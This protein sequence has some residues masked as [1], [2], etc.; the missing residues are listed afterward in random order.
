MKEFHKKATSDKTW[1]SFK[2]VFTEKYNDLAEKT[3][4]TNRDA[5]FHSADEIQEIR[6]L[7][8]H[9]AMAE[10]ANKNIVTKLTEAVNTLTRNNTS[11]TKK[12]SDTI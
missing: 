2:K 5:G 11:L 9:L 3:K 4:V 8:E 10:V 12:L 6:G 1:A 7:L